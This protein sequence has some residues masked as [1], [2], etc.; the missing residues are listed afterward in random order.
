M[1]TPNERYIQENT[2]TSHKRWESMVVYALHYALRNV[3]IKSQYS[4]ENIYKIDAYL[5]SI[6][7]AIEIDEEYHVNNLINDDIR[8]KFI[9]QKIG[10]TFIRI[11]ITE[12]VYDQVDRIVKYVNELKLPEWIHEIPQTVTHTGEFSAAKRDKLEKAGTYIFVEKFKSK[13]IEQ[14]LAVFNEKNDGTGNGMLGVDIFFDGLT[15]KAITGTSKKIKFQVLK[16]DPNSVL[17][18][19]IIISDLVQKKYWNIIGYEKACSEEKALELL[20]SIRDK[21]G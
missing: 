11:N 5:P 12:D 1:A 7:L 20:I 21:I 16:F 3:E 10:C 2:R 19:G 4:V 8:Q 6:N 9:E 15:L 13:C 18:A 14:D 17:K